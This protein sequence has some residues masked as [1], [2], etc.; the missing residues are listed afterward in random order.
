V[1]A[2]AEFGAASFLGGEDS[3]AEVTSLFVADAGPVGPTD[4]W[5]DVP[6]VVGAV[7]GPVAG[8]GEVIKGPVARTA[9]AAGEEFGAV[10]NGAMASFTGAVVAG[11]LGRGTEMFDAVA[12]VE[13][14]G[15]LADEF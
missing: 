5:R 10:A 3:P 9:I 15:I 7:V 13:L 14:P 2:A 1:G 6:V 4:G 12:V 8:A 11:E